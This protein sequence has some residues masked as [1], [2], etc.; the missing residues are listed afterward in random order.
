MKDDLVRSKFQIDAS[1][2]VRD[3]AKAFAYK[4]GLSLNDFVLLAIAQA[5]DKEL[6]Q[7]I[8]KEIGEDKKLP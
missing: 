2:K 1:K 8:Q 4:N 5:G 6:K 7:L 3:H